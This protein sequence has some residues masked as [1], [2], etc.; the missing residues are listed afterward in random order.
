[1]AIFSIALIA[2]IHFLFIPLVIGL[3]FMLYIENIFFEKS[4]ILLTDLFLINFIFAIL[5]GMIFAYELKINWNFLPQN[6]KYISKINTYFFLIIELILFALLKKQKKKN[7]SLLLLICIVC[8]IIPNILIAAWMQNPIS[9]TI[10]NNKIICNLKELFNKTFF[11]K[12]THILIAS[13]LTAAACL[14]SIYS[15]KKQLIKLNFYSKIGIIL[16]IIMLLN[17]HY[18]TKELSLS[19]S[20]KFVAMENISKNNTNFAY[21]LLS[22]EKYQT[23]PKNDQNNTL[24]YSFHIMIF[25]FFAMLF[26]F[27]FKFK[28]VFIFPL[29]ANFCGWLLAEHGRKPWIIYNVLLTKDAFKNEA[30]NFYILLFLSIIICISYI[31]IIKKKLNE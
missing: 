15:F 27:I 12:L 16:S 3:P 6:L 4:D 17:A 30:N 1:M 5:T 22:K 21:L 7:I 13:A 25:C 18:K 24:F 8:S 11:F 20:K 14:C 9:T 10:I 26:S 23:L 2:N 28:Y 19:Q 29:I 31:Y